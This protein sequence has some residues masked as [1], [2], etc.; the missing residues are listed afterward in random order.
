M[1]Q[2]GR[3]LTGLVIGAVLVLAAGPANAAVSDG[4]MS[5]RS[6]SAAKTPDRS[7]AFRI[8][9]KR[10]RLRNA[11]GVAVGVAAAA[12]ILNEAAKAEKRRKA[13]KRARLRARQGRNCHSDV[14]VHYHRALGGSEPHRHNSKCVAYVVYPRDS[15]VAAA[16][17]P[18]CDPGYEY[19][20]GRCYRNDEL[21]ADPRDDRR[22]SYDED[23]AYERCARKYRSFSY[24]DGTFQ[25]YGDR[26][27]QLCPYLE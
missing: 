24:E 16:P 21:D 14:R 15:D 22:A 8:A 25:P 19:I 7:G 1:K 3:R 12:I 6:V 11:V 5:S 10:K 18:R 26:P 4:A 13:R 20:E 23:A 2:V 17:P 9:K 27:R